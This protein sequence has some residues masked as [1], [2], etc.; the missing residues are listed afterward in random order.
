MG[1]RMRVAALIL[2]ILSGLW[3]VGIALFG[4]GLLFVA[5]LADVAGGEQWAML[6]LYGLPALALIGGAL[7]LTMPT[8][9]GGLLLAGVV[10]WFAVGALFGQGINLVTIAP[11][12]LTWT[13]AF[14]ALV[15]GARRPSAARRPMSDPRAAAP[16]G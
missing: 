14:L 5:A 8:V 7:A 16:N 15:D 9:A 4:G 3:G 10:G 12:M 13:A 11:L 6:A 1:A 2:G